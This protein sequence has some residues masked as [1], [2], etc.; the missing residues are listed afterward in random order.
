MDDKTKKAADSVKDAAEEVLDFTETA[1]ADI[2]FKLVSV[3][4]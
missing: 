2:P 3:I 4:E 1:A